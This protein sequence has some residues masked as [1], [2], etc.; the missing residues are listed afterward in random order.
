M[1]DSLHTGSMLPYLKKGRLAV[2][3]VRYIGAHP[4]SLLLKL[5]RKATGLSSLT[6]ISIM[7]LEPH[8]RL[9]RGSQGPSAKEEA[10]TGRKEKKKKK[11]RS[12]QMATA[13]NTSCTFGITYWITYRCT[14]R[15]TTQ[16]PS[17]VEDEDAAEAEGEGE[18]G[19]EGE[20]A[21]EVRQRVNEGLTGQRRLSSA[22][23]L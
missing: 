20:G 22:L 13:F 1:F 9:L 4:F 3:C 10:Q 15:Q 14:K 19:G 2:A 8:P 18:G 21:E 17:E 16:H 12:R 11:Y 5:K 6:R 7:Y 23:G